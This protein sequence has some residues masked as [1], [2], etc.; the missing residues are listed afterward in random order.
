MMM[1]TAREQIVA[2]CSRMAADGL[3]LGTAG[4]IS[5]Y[6]PELHC[7]AISPSGRIMPSISSSG[8]R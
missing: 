7:M 1:K 4:N 5:I 3:T 2:Y 6:D 8:L